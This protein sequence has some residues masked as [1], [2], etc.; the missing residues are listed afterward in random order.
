MINII[1]FI[2]PSAVGKSTLRDMLGFERIVTYTSRTKRDGELDGVDYHFTTKE[3]ILSMYESNSLLEYSEYNGN[4]YATPLSSFENAIENKQLVTIIVDKNGAVT[5]KEKFSS[6]IMVIGVYA[7]LNECEERMIIRSDQNTAKRLESYN[8][9]LIAQNNLSDILV[10][11]AK[12][13]WHKSAQL[14]NLL[15]TGINGC[16]LNDLKDLTKNYC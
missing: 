14:M 13:N 3:R 9:E 2:G 1:A 5:L 15:K 4:L 16:N 8:D 11:N 10:N 6:K 7:P 12:V